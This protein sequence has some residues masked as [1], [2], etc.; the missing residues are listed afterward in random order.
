MILGILLIVATPYSNV[1]HA[2][3]AGDWVMSHIWMSHVTHMIESCHTYEWVM[4]HIWMSH[5]TH[6]NESCH[7]YEWVMSHTWFRHVTHMNESCHTYSYAL[8]WKSSYSIFTPSVHVYWYVCAHPRVTSHIR[9][10]HVT[11]TVMS[12]F[13]RGHIPS[14]PWERVYIDMG[15]LPLVGSLK[16]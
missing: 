15:W 2:A 7:T 6:M 5:V 11:H 3:I 1:W 16:L 14:W 9:M 10:S 8:F 4:S 13:E 12:R